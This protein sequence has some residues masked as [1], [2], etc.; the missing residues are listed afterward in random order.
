MFDN[1]TTCR[2]YPFLSL[3]RSLCL[4]RGVGSS[5]LKITKTSLQPEIIPR[6]K[7]A[8]K[9][10]PASQTPSNSQPFLHWVCR[11][12]EDNAIIRSFRPPRVPRNARSR[13]TATARRAAASPRGSVQRELIATTSDGESVS[14]R[15][16]TPIQAL[17]VSRWRVCTKIIRIHAQPTEPGRLPRKER[18]ER[19]RERERRWLLVGTSNGIGYC[20]C[21]QLA[22]QNSVARTLPFVCMQQ[23]IVGSATCLVSNRESI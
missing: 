8:N 1:V 19:E 7:S 17:C 14:Q 3:S 10:K 11:S 4:S 23:K 16:L 5:A 15:D 13:S 20:S 18:R 21:Q 22:P 2:Y 9:C 12:F 6:N